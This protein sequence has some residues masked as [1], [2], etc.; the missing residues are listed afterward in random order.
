MG[1]PKSQHAADG[2]DQ[3]GAVEGVEVEGVD[4]FAAQRLDLFGG[5]DGGHQIAGFRVR[6][7]AGKAAGQVGRNMGAAF[8]RE[9]ADAGE[10]GDGQNAGHQFDVDA[11]GKDAVAQAQEEG[12]VEEELRDGAA[13][14]VFGLVGHEGQVFFDRHRFRMAL[15]IGGD[16]DFEVG[17]VADAAHQIGGVA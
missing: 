2:I 4:A 12:I 16:G 11:A 14:A 5:D 13:G 15:G 9:F 8:G 6:I 17:D 3:I 10:V 7:E 1:V